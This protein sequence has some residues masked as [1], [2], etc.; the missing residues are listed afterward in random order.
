MGVTVR[1]TVLTSSYPRFPGDGTAPFVQSICEH[2]VKLGHLIEVVAPYDPA[3]RK[4]ISGHVVMHWF[5]YTLVKRWHIMGYAKSLVGDNH[6]RG[7]V[8][9][10]L[11]FYLGA[12]F[13]CT[14]RVAL[15]QKAEL[16][17]AHWLLPNGLVGMWAAYL[18]HIP[19]VVSL[20][21]S[22]VFV[23]QRNWLFRCVARWVLRCATVVT[24]CSEDLYRSALSLGASMDRV[25]LITWGVDHFRFH[26]QIPPLSRSEFGLREDDFVVIALGRI[27][28]KK[29]FDILV[30]ALPLL[31]KS[32]PNVHIVIGGDGVQREELLRLAAELKVS[33]HLHMP[34]QISWDRVPAFLAMGDVFVLPS[35]RDT[36]GNSD[37]LPTVLLE[38][39]ALGK[40]I[41]ATNIGGVPLVITDGVNGLLCPSGDHNSLSQSI[42]LLVQDTSLRQRLGQ[43]A[44]RSVEEQFNWQEVARRF[45]EIFN[46]SINRLG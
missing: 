36:S 2:L 34:G 28:P 3:V 10:L 17:H 30:R 37:G 44:R 18:L 38:A 43:S 27:V 24:A 40:P 26:P 29:G 42:G 25:R 23:A 32:Y 16:I 4:Q 20:H 12:Q 41:V 14:L 45:T 33:E 9:F 21:G 11:P 7:G 19:L 15:K 39:M 35:K 46:Q 13:W 6:F 31:L 8:F 22:D 5:R 1:V